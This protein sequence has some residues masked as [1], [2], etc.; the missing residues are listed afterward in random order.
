[1]NRRLTMTEHAQRYL[2]QRRSLGLSLK[3][4]ESILLNF[5]RYLD[6]S[7]HRD[8][9]TTE[10]IMRWVYLPKSISQSYRSERLSIARCFARYLAVRDGCSQVPDRHLVPKVHIRRQPHLYGEQDL[11]KLLD[12]AGRLSATFPMRRLTYQT[13]L[14]LLAC[15][16]VR[17]S[18]AI[19]LTCGQVDLEEGILRVERTKFKKSR[20]VPLHPSA[21]QALR[22]YAKARNQQWG[23]DRDAPFFL[24]RRGTP[25]SRYRVCCTFRRLCETL[26]WHRGNG[27]L[28]RPRIHD[29][30]H[31][32]A[33]RRLLS[34]YRQGRDV[35]HLIASLSTYLGHGNVTSTYWY[36][37]ATP[38][39]LAVAADRFE[40]FA[41]PTGG[42]RL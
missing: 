8:P 13:L 26:G 23:A 37:T 9:L 15:T 36:L 32:F 12:A 39:L 6:N 24:G 38:E 34:W 21:A 31:S 40:G 10:V 2:Q 5:T 1:M 19:K 28:P 22:R 11:K 30:R 3:A 14:G 18:E 17:V 16:G 25:L 4:A 42:R 35:Q 20:L 41:C 7:R 33:C 27:E 29:L